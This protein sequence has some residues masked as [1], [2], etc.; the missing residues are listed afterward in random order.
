MNNHYDLI[1]IGGGSGGLAVAEKAAALGKRVAIVEAKKLGGTCVN[2]GCVPKKIMW[3][4]A[5]LATAVSDAPDFGIN[6]KNLGINWSHLIAGRDRYI[7]D[8]NRYWGSYIEQQ[9]INRINGFA[10]FTAAHT[11]EVE[12]KSYTANHIV[13]AT[14]GQPIVPPVQGA[15]FKPRYHLRWILPTRTA[16]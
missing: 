10:K 12:G 13:I 5:Q 11:I 15:G 3:Q 4:A 9:G 6:V 2:A 14:G 1:T 7:R 8:I 16:T